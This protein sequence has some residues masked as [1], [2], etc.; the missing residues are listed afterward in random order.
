ME[1][2]GSVRLRLSLEPDVNKDGIDLLLEANDVMLVEAGEKTEPFNSYIA[3]T[4]AIK[5]NNLH[6]EKKKKT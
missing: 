4:F 1:S 3:S 5:A 6:T 2:T